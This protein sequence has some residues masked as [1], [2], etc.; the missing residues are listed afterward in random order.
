LKISGFFFF[1]SF[2]PLLYPL[3]LSKMLILWRGQFVP[4]H[5]F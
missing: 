4:Q 2:Y 5:L 3:K 1:F